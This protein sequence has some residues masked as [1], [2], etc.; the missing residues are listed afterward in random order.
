M[1]PIAEH[2]LVGL[3]DPAG[4]ISLRYGYWGARQMES[5]GLP[6]ELAVDAKRLKPSSLRVCRDLNILRGSQ[7]LTR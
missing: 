6:G 1:R 4:M 3:E 5:P 2:K 7:W